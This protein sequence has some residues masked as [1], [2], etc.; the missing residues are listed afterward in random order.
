[1]YFSRAH[2][3]LN[4][5]RKNACISIDSSTLLIASFISGMGIQLKLLINILLMASI[6]ER[7]AEFS[8]ATKNCILQ[9]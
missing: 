2:C 9:I 3:T 8:L 7:K 4:E 6:M 5:T 1:V